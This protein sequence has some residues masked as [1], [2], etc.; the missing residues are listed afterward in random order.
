MWF[1]KGTKYIE[2]SNAKLAF[3]TTNSISQGEQVDILWNPILR[4]SVQIFFAHKAFKWSNNAKYNAAVICSI[5]GLSA[6]FC[7]K[8]LFANGESKIVSNINPYLISADN[9]IITGFSNPIAKVPEMSFGSMPNDGG[10]LLLEKNEKEELINSDNECS[11]FIHRIYGS[12]EFIRDEER[13]CIWIE[14]NEKDALPEPIFNR[15]KQVGSVRSKS[16]RAATN[17][18]AAVPWRFGEVRYKIVMLS[19]YLRYHL[20]AENT[21]LLVMFQ[22][23]QLF[24]TLLLLF[25]TQVNGYLQYLLHKCIIYG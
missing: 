23:A 19:L 7:T 24:L 8:R 18:L 2:N 3:V 14:D 1:W 6:K 17:K 22:R 16:K 21:F 13:Y 9:T 5:I 20:S 12:Q 25:M 4:K 15:V 11:R 10:Y